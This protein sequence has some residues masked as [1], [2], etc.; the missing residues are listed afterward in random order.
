VGGR[1][2][3]AQVAGGVIGFKLLADPP[4]QWL[5]QLLVGPQGLAAG[6][7]EADK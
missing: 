4:V 6:N 2:A 7:N 3:P 1:H 5:G